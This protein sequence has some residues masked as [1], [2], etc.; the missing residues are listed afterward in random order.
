VGD[1]PIG[2]LRPLAITGTLGINFPDAGSTDARSLDTGFAIE[3]SIPYL[4]DQVQD[5]GLPGW[6]SR[7]VPLIEITNSRPFDRNTGVATT[8]TIAPGI[9]YS[10]RDWQLGAEALLPGTSGT[11]TGKGFQ[12]Q[13]HLFLGELFPSAFEKPIF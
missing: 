10:S 4:Q 11:H 6:I 12:V 13:L 1:L 3:Y 5:F 7:L 2:L 8:G 9:I